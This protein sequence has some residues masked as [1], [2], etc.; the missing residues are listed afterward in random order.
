MAFFYEFIENKTQKKILMH[1]IKKL[2]KELLNP[3]NQ[4]TL[5]LSYRLLKAYMKRNPEKKEMSF[6]L[7]NFFLF[8]Q[9]IANILNNVIVPMY[10]I[11][12]FK[13]E[14]KGNLNLK[15]DLFK[16]IQILLSK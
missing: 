5:Y 9:S 15:Y 11:Y 10:K 2:R 4:T 6:I 8:F 7:L 12:S 16:K 13:R 3:R 14:N 1:L